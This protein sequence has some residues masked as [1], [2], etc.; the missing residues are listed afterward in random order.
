MKNI[1]SIFLLC[2]IAGMALLLTTPSAWAGS[3]KGDN[4][5]VSFHLETDGTTNPKMIFDQVITN[6]KM[7]FS[8][9]PDFTSRDIIAFS[10]FLADDMVTYGAVFQLRGS[11]KTKLENLST[12]NRGKLLC[13][14]INGRV[15]DAVLIDKTIEDGLLVIWN[16]ILDT[17][18]KGYDKLVPRIGGKKK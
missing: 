8:R 10:P 15:V 7:F 4:L 18:V 1:R 14:K 6:K 3:K 9:M 12:A 11:A 5:I 2:C 13:A 17:E 16:G